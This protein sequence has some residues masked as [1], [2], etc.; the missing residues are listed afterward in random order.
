MITFNNVNES[1]RLVLS[2]VVA[3]LFSVFFAI[4]AGSTTSLVVMALSIVLILLGGK[5]RLLSVLGFVYGN[6]I[7]FRQKTA[8][9]MISGDWSSDVWASDLDVGGALEAIKGSLE[10][11]ANDE[12]KIGR[13]S[14]RERV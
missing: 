8:Y 5:L 4:Y 14:C 10:K 7:F 9:E 13:A 6:L 1:I 2:I 12:V 11:I 3:L